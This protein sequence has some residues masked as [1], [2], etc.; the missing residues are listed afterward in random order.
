MAR[1]ACLLGPIG[2]NFGQHA[3]FR[4]AEGAF[5]LIGKFG[6]RLWRAPHVVAWH[7][8]YTPYKYD[9]ARFNTPPTRG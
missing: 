3:R 7:D 8:N 4:R 6:G 9:L 2:S 1:A 5:E